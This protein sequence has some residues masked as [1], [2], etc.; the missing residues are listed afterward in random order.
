MVTKEAELSKKAQETGQQHFQFLPGDKMI[1]ASPEGIVLTYVHGELVSSK[2][3][4]QVQLESQI[5]ESTIQVTANTTTH[6]TITPEVSEQIVLGL[7]QQTKQ[8]LTGEQPTPFSVI[9]PEAIFQASSGITPNMMA[10]ATGSIIPKG[11]EME[12]GQIVPTSQTFKTSTGETFTA[13]PTGSSAL[14]G[15]IWETPYGEVRAAPNQLQKEIGRTLSIQAMTPTLLADFEKNKL[16]TE[17]ASRLE[18]GMAYGLYHPFETARGLLSYA[19]P[20]FGETR[21]EIQLE[22]WKQRR[23]WT[24]GMLEAGPVSGIGFESAKLGGELFLATAGGPILGAVGSKVPSIL[25][26]VL[27]GAGLG[28][29][30]GLTAIGTIE[31]E[32]G[33][34]EKSTQRFFGGTLLAGMGAMG[35]KAVW[36][37][38]VVPEL[39]KAFPSKT[40]T[41]G[42]SVSN[43]EFK[44]EDLV[45]GEG[46][47]IYDTK[48]RG[49]D[50]ISKAD[51]EFIGKNVD[52]KITFSIEGG[53]ME[54][55]LIEPGFLGL[56]KKVTDLDDVMFGTGAI[57]TPAPREDFF[58][59]MFKS[60]TPKTD[61][62]GIG[63]SEK[64]FEGPSETIFRTF[65]ET[66][67]GRLLSIDKIIDMTKPLGTFESG[68]MGTIF[69][70]DKGNIIKA[71]QKD[72]L[73]MHGSLI[74]N[75]LIPSSESSLIPTIFPFVESGTKI[76][77]ETKEDIFSIPRVKLEQI[78]EEK[79]LE[80]ITPSITL[81]G[82]G[83]LLEN[84]EKERLSIVP[85]EALAISSAQ[86]ERQLEPT[87]LKEI[88]VTVTDVIT[89]ITL[90]PIASII[91]ANI[92]FFGLPDINLGFEE[93]RRRRGKSY[94]RSFFYT[95]SFIALELNI[96]GVMP[97]F[98]TGFEI[99]PLLKGMRGL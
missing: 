17:R 29:T 19:F 52:N 34:E 67:S 50:V 33:I 66:E 79:S 15:F 43:I 38:G 36:E 40:L 93:P 42:K 55:K 86:A 71:V 11:F 28:L 32:K 68:G 98:L 61:E 75:I 80:A 91:P 27:T 82:V 22:L 99:R 3:P 24:A 59:S 69:E 7:Q 65:A 30:T 60:V 14:G 2:T 1:V 51:F 85:A 37:A 13:T 35:T 18:T 46:A 47:G 78:T 48:V 90:V 84:L 83:S 39:E 81:I 57:T 97:K 58:V 16:I 49:K 10:G 76:E 45:G 25:Q 94:G 87:M 12:G 74:E 63:I 20:L 31:A 6:P 44:Q 9:T 70:F 77:T 72:V 96:R 62:M 41:I 64:I 89:P 92:P 4:S 56:G 21:E 73:G 88:T 8:A 23:D 53:K 54:S 95:P 5:S 26:P